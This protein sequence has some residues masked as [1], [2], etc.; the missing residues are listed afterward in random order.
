MQAGVKTYSMLIASMMGVLV[1]FL[2]YNIWGDEKKKRK[3]FMGDSGSLT[4]G[5][6]LAFLYIKVTMNMDDNQVVP[7]DET[8]IILANSLLIVPA[9]DVLRVSIIRIKHRQP[10]FKAD[11]N[12]IH[13]KLIRAGLSQHQ[14]L[15]AIICLIFV[16]I[17]LNLSLQ[18]FVS[19]TAIVAID[20]LIWFAFHLFINKV[21]TKR[22]KSVFTYISP[23]NDNT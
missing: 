2:Y 4:L 16:F 23:Q 8:S 19:L 12:H 18:H 15:L 9:L 14:A 3:I 13:H 5:F 20:I 17:I 11:K 7:F 6:I 22:G 21:I 10:M 1:P